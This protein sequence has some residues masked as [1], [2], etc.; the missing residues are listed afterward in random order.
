MHTVPRRRN[1]AGLCLWGSARAVR[2]LCAVEIL[3]RAHLALLVAS[4]VHWTLHFSSAVVE[5]SAKSVA[6][7]VNW[8]LVTSTT[9]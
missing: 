5:D 8:S 3:Q 2:P 9:P 6:G 7:G 4:A 1:V